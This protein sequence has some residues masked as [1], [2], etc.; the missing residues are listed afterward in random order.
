MAENRPHGHRL[1]K[2]RYSAGGNVYLITACCRSRLAVFA[3]LDLGSVV[4]EEIRKSDLEN[5]SDTYAF[6]V[7]PDHLHWLFQLRAGNT[8]SSVVRKI[9]GV[10]AYRI[11]KIRRSTDAVWQKGYYDR[12]LRDNESLIEAGNYVIA[13]PVQAGLV[14]RV[15]DY[16][17]W[18]LMLAN[19][20]DANRG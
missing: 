2:C 9:K 1:R 4:A 14:A 19:E 15:E 7:M 3:N 8:L 18:G 16:S 13:N 11:N 10:S 17:L 12:A 20:R 6:V 5:R